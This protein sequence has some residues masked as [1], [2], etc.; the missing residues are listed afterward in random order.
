MHPIQA[1]ALQLEIAIARSSLRR[2]RH[3][4]AMRHL[5]RAHILG[6]RSV[7]AHVLVHWLMFVVAVARR[8]PLAAFGQIVRIVLG[9]FGS[10]I[11]VVPVGN[12]GGSDVSMFAPMEIPADL[13]RLVEGGRR[14]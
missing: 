6:Q 4:R 12:T 11:G 10:A 3:E 5:E 7:R 1:H 13:A 8:Q 9:A 2:G 14:V